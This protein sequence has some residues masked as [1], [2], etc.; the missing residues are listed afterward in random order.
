V[1]AGRG[2]EAAPELVLVARPGSYDDDSDICS[3]GGGDCL[4]ESGLVVGP[5]LAALG[6]GD[7]AFASGLDAVEGSDTAGGGLVNDIVSVLFT[8]G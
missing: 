7:L 6:V 3:L 1:L 2:V 4:I 8:K 5:A